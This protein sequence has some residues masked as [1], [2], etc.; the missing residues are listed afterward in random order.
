MILT[1]K[2]PRKKPGTLRR[3]QEQSPGGERELSL[4]PPSKGT[5]KV[6]VLGPSRLDSV[7]WTPPTS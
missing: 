3:S 6:K 7:P 4:M 5:L 2:A 1:S